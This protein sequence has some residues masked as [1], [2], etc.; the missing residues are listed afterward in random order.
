MN[1]LETIKKG[2]ATASIIERDNG[3]LFVAVDCDGRQS[4]SDYPVRYDNGGISWNHPERLPKYAKALGVEML[5]RMEQL[6]FVERAEEIAEELGEPF[7]F[8]VKWN[9]FGNVGE[10]WQDYRTRVAAE[11]CATRKNGTV[12]NL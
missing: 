2:K 10:V 4:H 11:D 3:A 1:I 5:D 6:R 9:V 12:S 7:L 8:R